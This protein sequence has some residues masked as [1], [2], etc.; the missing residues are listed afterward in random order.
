[1]SLETPIYF[2]TRLEA[3]LL[4]VE[5]GGR[6]M[7]YGLNFEARRSGIKAE[8]YCIKNWRSKKTLEDIVSCH[9][10]KSEGIVL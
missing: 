6:V 9:S 7:I 10:L 1:L 5:M 8:R 2:A 3:L 4:L